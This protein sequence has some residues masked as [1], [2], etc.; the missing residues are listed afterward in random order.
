MFLQRRSYGHLVIFTWFH[1]QRFTYCCKYAFF[2]SFL[3]CAHFQINLRSVR[4]SCSFYLYRII[5]PRIFPGIELN[6]FYHLRLHVS[7][8]KIFKRFNCSLIVHFDSCFLTRVKYESSSLD[9]VL[10]PSTILND[11]FLC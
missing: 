3:F 11:L 5:F 8:W 2:F 6:C 4:V 7:C 1:T 10:L 9:C